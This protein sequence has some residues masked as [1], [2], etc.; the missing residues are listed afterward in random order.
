MG[1][2]CSMDDRGE[3]CVQ[4]LVGMQQGKR[5]RTLGGRNRKWEDH[6]KIYLTEITREYGLD[7]SIKIDKLSTRNSQQNSLGLLTCCIDF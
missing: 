7:S 3:K 6:I 2:T 4:I 5:K 1:R